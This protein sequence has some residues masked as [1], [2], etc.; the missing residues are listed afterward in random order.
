[1]FLYGL[2]NE[3]LPHKKYNSYIKYLY[4]CEFFDYCLALWLPW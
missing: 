1:M 3:S 4:T 2:L